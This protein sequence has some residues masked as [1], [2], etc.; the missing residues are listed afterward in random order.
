M[1][2]TDEILNFEAEVFKLLIEL[3]GIVF[4]ISLNGSSYSLSL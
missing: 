4:S 2:L 3:S 1:S